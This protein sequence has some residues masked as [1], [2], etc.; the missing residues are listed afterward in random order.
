MTVRVV[1]VCGPVDVLN[2]FDRFNT[3]LFIAVSVEKS[4]FGKFSAGFNKVAIAFDAVPS[5]PTM[6]AAVLCARLES[7]PVL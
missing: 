3:M 6:L 4:R 5:T 2:I 1:L 7:V